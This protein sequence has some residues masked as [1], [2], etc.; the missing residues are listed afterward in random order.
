MHGIHQTPVNCLHKGQWRGA[1]MFSLICA[2]MNGW[3]NKCEAGDLR[4]HHAHYDVT[5]MMFHRYHGRYTLVTPLKYQR[6]SATQRE[7]LGKAE[8]PLTEK[9]KKGTKVMPFPVFAR[10]P[11]VFI[12]RCSIVFPSATRKCPYVSAC[13]IM[14]DYSLC[15]GYKVVCTLRVPNIMCTF[16]NQ[17]QCI[18]IQQ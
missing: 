5:V 8:L 1:L 6:D 11:Q 3:V 16:S 15:H 14:G 9:W 17:C 7:I 10:F 12:W 4:C 2:W 18:H 13:G